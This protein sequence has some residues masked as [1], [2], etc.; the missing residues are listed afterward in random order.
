MALA[1]LTRHRIASFSVES[2]RYCGIKDFDIYRPKSLSKHTGSVDAFLQQC[3]DMY[4]ELV[5]NGVPP[6]DARYLMPQGVKTR[7]VM[8]MNVQ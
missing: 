4:E 7:L 3:Q 5:Q 1:Q 6:E 8:T 2:Q